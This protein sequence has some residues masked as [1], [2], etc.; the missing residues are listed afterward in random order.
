MLWGEQH[1]KKYLSQQSGEKKHFDLILGSDLIYV[2]SV[3]QP[4]F[5]TVKTLLCTHENAKFL[6]AHCSRREGNEV[7]L[8]MVLDSAREEGFE[9]DIIVEDDDISLFSFRRKGAEKET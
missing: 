7:E 2:Q 5:E 6:M 9:Y 8:S 3:I 4:L 1:A